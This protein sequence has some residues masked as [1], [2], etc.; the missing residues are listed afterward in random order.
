MVLAETFWQVVWTMFIFFLW[1]IWLWLLFTV[2]VDIFRNRQSSGFA[3]AGWSVFVILLPFLGVFVYL[4][5]EGKGMAERNVQRAQAQQAQMDTYV[6][7]VAGSGSA[8]EIA[9]A[10]DLLDSGAISQGE[11]DQLKAK[12]FTD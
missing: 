2:F 3:K 4:L 5:A 9:K 12:A 6:R 11:F 1:V 10:K 7:S 8:D